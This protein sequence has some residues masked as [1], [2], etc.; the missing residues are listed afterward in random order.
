MEAGAST[1]WVGTDWVEDYVIRR[2]GPDAYDRWTEGELPFDSPALTAVFEEL[3]D[4]LRG[5]GRSPAAGA[6]S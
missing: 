6:P 3:D 4:L 1:G 2:L 5:P